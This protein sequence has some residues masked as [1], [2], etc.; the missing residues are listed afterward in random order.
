MTE[1]IQLI[2]K[3]LEGVSGE[4]VFVS[5]LYIILNFLKPIAFISVLGFIV[6][7]ILNNYTVEK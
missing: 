3:A 2:V 7:K 5:C 4:A 1:E 6:M